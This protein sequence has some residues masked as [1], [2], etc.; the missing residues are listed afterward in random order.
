M[1]NIGGQIHYAPQPNYW[2]GH[3]PPAPPYRAP[4]EC[5][6]ISFCC[7]NHCLCT[8]V[9]RRDCFHQPFLR[10]HLETTLGTLS[11]AFFSKSRKANTASFLY[12]HTKCR[13]V[14]IASV[15]HFPVI[16]PNCIISIFHL[17]LIKHM[18]YHCPLHVPARQSACALRSWNGGFSGS[19][20]TTVRYSWSEAT[21]QSRFKPSGLQGLECHTGQSISDVDTWCWWSEAPTDGSMVWMHQSVID[22]WPVE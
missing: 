2:R 9:H 18:F 11:N 21:K 22:D 15:P 14:K 7:P 3:G 19:P 6:A 5:F 8:L 12:S 1:Q 20:N 4:H 13:T 16:N 10:A 17:F